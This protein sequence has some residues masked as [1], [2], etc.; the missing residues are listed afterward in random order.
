[1]LRETERKGERHFEEKKNLHRLELKHLSLIATHIHTLRN[2][3]VL[4]PNSVSNTSTWT[5]DQDRER[6]KE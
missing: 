5:T 1:M 2:T 6:K 3:K 4:T